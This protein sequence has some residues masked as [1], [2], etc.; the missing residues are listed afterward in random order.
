LQ[1]AHPRHLNIKD[2]ALGF[3]EMTRAQEILCRSEDLGPKSV[4]FQETHGR[5]TNRRIV[6]N[7]RNQ[8]YQ[9]VC[10]FIHIQTLTPAG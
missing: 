2:E 7:Y 3:I 4:G 9:M 6:I 1:T 10:F 5:L 8:G